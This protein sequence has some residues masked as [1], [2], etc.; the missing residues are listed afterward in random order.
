MNGDLDET[1]SQN[2][3]DS[4]PSYPP[5]VPPPEEPAQEP[6]TPQKQEPSSPL[7]SPAYETPPN[8]LPES[9]EKK[10]E[11][12]KDEEEEVQEDINLYEVPT[13]NKPVELPAG[14]LYQVG[15]SWILILYNLQIIYDADKCLFSAG[16]SV[17]CITI[18][19]VVLSRSDSTGVIPGFC[20]LRSNV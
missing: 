6:V 11:E 4:A 16:F 13:S 14:V 12:G 9:E 10:E 19:V 20:Y 5:P 2:S 17:R 7:G 8:K 1:V 15:S 18:S 3:E